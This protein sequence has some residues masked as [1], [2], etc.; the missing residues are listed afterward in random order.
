MKDSFDKMTTEELKAKKA[1]LQ[2]EQMNLRVNKVY[3]HLDN[4]LALRNNRRKIARINTRLSEIE[5][6]IR[7]KD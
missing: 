7:Q 2:K 4:P 1:E 6:G 5:L 3:A